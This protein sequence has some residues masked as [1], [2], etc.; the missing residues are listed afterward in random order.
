MANFI[1]KKAKESML[2]G[3][4]N[5]NSTN[6]KVLFV[7]TSNYSPNQNL[8]QFLSDIPSNAR[9]YNSSAVSNVSTASGVLDADDLTI[10]YDGASFQAIILYQSGNT[11]QDSRL[12]SFIDTSEG[13]PFSQTSNSVALSIQWDNS[14]TKIITI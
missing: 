4:I 7:N 2:N 12:I 6:L 8:N 13:L 14:S 9:V 3:Q 11:D 5:L 1:Y 10:T